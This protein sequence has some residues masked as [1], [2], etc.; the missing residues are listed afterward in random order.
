MTR[1]IGVQ[2]DAHT[3]IPL[4]MLFDSWGLFLLTQEFGRHDGCSLRDSIQNSECFLP[5]GC[6]FI[7]WS[8]VLITLLVAELEA[9]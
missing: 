1:L 9:I 7:F 8:P 2:G 6:S 4:V 3:P 5:I